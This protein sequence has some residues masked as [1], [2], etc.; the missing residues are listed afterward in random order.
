MQSDAQSPRDI[1]VWLTP[2]HILPLVCGL[3]EN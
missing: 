2:M 1:C 3:I